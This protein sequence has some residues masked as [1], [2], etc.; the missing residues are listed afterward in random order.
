MVNRIKNVISKYGAINDNTASDFTKRLVKKEFIKNSI[1]QNNSEVANYIFFVDKGLIRHYYIHNNKEYTTW[2]S[3]ENE[4][5]SNSSFFLRKPVSEIIET[6]EDSVLY[7]ITYNDYEELCS[8]Y[9]DFEHLVRLIITDLFLSLDEHFAQLIIMSATERYK[10][11][12]EKYPNFVKRIPLIYIAS[13][14]GIA[15]ETLS[16]VRRKM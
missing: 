3:Q 13:F 14:L 5:I 8:K 12:I 15:P 10:L 9:H 11:L 1:I 7:G 2:F 4:F 16:R 6:L